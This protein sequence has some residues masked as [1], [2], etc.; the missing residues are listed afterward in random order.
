LQ[1]WAKIKGK[2]LVGDKPIVG[3]KVLLGKNG[4]QEILI[5]REIS[6]P[7]VTDENGVFE[8]TKLKAGLNYVSVELEGT[9]SQ[10]FVLCKGGETSEI[11]IGGQGRPLTAKVSVSGLSEL[12]ATV[13]LHEEILKEK[14]P[15]VKLPIALYL[16]PLLEKKS[17]S[18]AKTRETDFYE[19]REEFVA[20]QQQVKIGEDGTMRF[21]NVVSGKYRF[22]AY[23]LGESDGQI[24]AA[25]APFEVTLDAGKTLDTVAQDLGVVELERR[26][27]HAGVS[28]PN[29]TFQDL[30]G[31]TRSSSEFSGK[32]WVLLLFD[33]T[34]PEGAASFSKI[35]A[36]IID[37]PDVRP[38]G[39][40]VEFLAL[41][42]G[43]ER[44][45][46]DKHWTNYYWRKQNL[47]QLTTEQEQAL[48]AFGFGDE[49]PQYF[50]VD[51][52]GKVIATGFGNILQWSHLRKEAF[53]E[54][55]RK[56]L[57]EESR[58]ALEA[59]AKK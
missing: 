52:D 4:L 24:E 37:F 27:I 33:A 36:N 2:V 40:K 13:R 41:H 30:Q 20:R 58:K 57:Q 45:E 23:T 19:N 28:A 48:S 55:V 29:F 53:R 22:V 25:S 17:T 47:G 32:T 54:G 21:E 34:A 50:L 14:F 44:K 35:E 46:L 31:K 39:E 51:K 38:D 43:K 15:G 9:A 8:F 56:T 59:N 7:L 1:K 49:S 3:A 16:A 18:A 12:D 5:G 6:S 11:T 42:R 26:K 10:R